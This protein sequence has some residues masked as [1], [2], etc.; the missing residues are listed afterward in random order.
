MPYGA[1]Q[2]KPGRTPGI[3]GV[4]ILRLPDFVQV[5]RVIPEL[6]PSGKTLRLVID[7]DVANEIDDLYAIALALVSP[8]RFRFEGLI[9]ANYKNFAPGAGPESIEKSYALGIQLINLAGMQGKYP[10]IRGAPPCQYY[11]FPSQGEGV[12]FII[13]RAHAGSEDD[14][15]WV[16]GLGTATDLASAILKD[17]T[18]MPK[19]RFVFHGR[20]DFTWPQRSVQFNVK[21]DIHAART[22]LKEWVPLVWFDTGTHLC[23]DYK[24]TEKCLA[25]AGELGKFIHNYR[26]RDP[27]FRSLDKGFFDMGDIAWMIEPE[28]CK[29]ELVRAPSMDEYMF[30]DHSR[31]N[32]KMLRIFD[33][34]N[35]QTWNMLF[36]RMA[37]FFDSKNE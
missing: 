5:D 14:P 35:D 2:P 17:P 27:Y 28:I 22:L 1:Y 34:D 6:P 36:Q 4:S 15:L 24:I 11:G 25:P 10:I 30:F 20:S 7:S 37:K 13:E 21:G 23:A 32:G 9:G 12:D 26:N 18:I 31:P 16:V 29:S 8:D 3:E 19:V 33:I